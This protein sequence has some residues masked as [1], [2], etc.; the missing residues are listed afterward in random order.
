MVDAHMGKSF[1]PKDLG[2]S[3]RPVTHICFSSLLLFFEPNTVLACHIDFCKRNIK[4]A[5]R[6]VHCFPRGAFKAISLSDHVIG[7]CPEIALAF[8]EVLR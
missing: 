3:A 1:I 6:P 4:L 7:R 5:W 2:L 8:P